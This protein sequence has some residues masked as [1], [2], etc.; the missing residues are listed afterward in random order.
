MPAYYAIDAFRIDQP[1]TRIQL[2]ELLAQRAGLATGQILQVRVRKASLDARKK[3]RIFQILRLEI[4][5]IKPLNPVPEGWQQIPTWTTEPELPKRQSPSAPIHVI[6]VGS[7]PAGLFAAVLLA[8]S[9]VRVTLLERGKAV[10]PRMRDI[11]QLRSKGILLPESNVCFGEGGAG[12]YTDGKLYTRIKHPW[13]RCVMQ[14][15]VEWGAPDDILVEAHPHLGTDK[16][17]DILIQLREHLQQRGTEILFENKMKR[18]LRHQE[19]V[20]GVELEDGRELLADAVVL[21]IG[22]SARETLA[23]LHRQGVKL[24]AK[25]FAVGV[26]V[27]HPQVLINENQF[28]KAER[29]PIW[30]AAEYRL[31]HNVK[32]AFGE[33]GIYSFCMC[34][35]GFIVPSPTE[36]GHMAVNGMSNANRST[37]FANSGIVVQI[38]PSDLVQMGYAESPLCGIAFQ[39]DLEK[40]C[41]EA[42]P[43]PYH[44]PASRISDFL[45]KKTPQTLAPTH[46][47]P[48]AVAHDLWQILPNAVAEPLAEALRAFGRKIH[49]FTSEEANMFAIESRT[50]SPIR[51]TREE[52]GEAIGWPGLYPVGEGAGYA[53]GIVSA[54]VDGLKAAEHILAQLDKSALT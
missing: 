38:E 27:E 41:F 49:G 47:R 1:Y 4:E 51:L 11:G 28:G 24:E 42:T 20:A 13:V 29:F 46:F 35:G 14:R 18:L 9:G 25:P 40:A 15:L 21:G 52:S 10:E 37:A 54:A 36:P 26:R 12:T 5:T 30:G 19:R 23:E 2:P 34:P 48:G 45:A 3:P 17:M 50:S 39:R 6:V 22:H 16:L 43:T 44:A 7:G 32:N 33:R 31:T 53:G 8:E